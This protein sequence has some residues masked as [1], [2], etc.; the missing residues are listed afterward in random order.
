MDNLKVRQPG[1]RKLVTRTI[2]GLLAV[3]MLVPVV[4]TILYS[5]CSPAEIGA[6]MKTRGKYD[7]SVWMEV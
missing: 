3:V 2:L 6:F 1:G 5:F 7:T 4:V